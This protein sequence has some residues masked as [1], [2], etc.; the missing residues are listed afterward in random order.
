MASR[1]RSSSKRG[2]RM[3]SKREKGHQGGVKASDHVFVRL[4]SSRRKNLVKI[5]SLSCVLVSEGRGIHWS[6][7]TIQGSFY[8]YS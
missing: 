2:E 4:S 6:Y 8:P 5:G 1:V 7:S 3:H